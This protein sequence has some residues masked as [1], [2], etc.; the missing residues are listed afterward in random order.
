MKIVIANVNPIHFQI[1]QRCKTL[2]SSISINNK[3]ELTVE[4]LQEIQPDFVFFLHWSHI[5]PQEVHEKFNCVVF[6]MTDLPFGRGGSPL[7]NLIVRGFDE[8]VISA[9]KV[10]EGIDTGPIFLKKRLYLGGTAE[11]IFLRA[12]KVM[13]E[14]IEIIVRE[15][16]PPV[17]QAGEVTIFKRRRPEESNIQ[18]LSETE[19]IFDF[20][21]MLDAENYPKAFIETEFFKFEFSRASLKADSVVAEVKITRKP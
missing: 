12:G 10:K 19:K 21:R 18:L 16:P 15:N 4:S 7:Q 11:E 8:T 3:N 14:M 1:E 13:L 20:I 9:I 17:P 6:H 2:F 5:I